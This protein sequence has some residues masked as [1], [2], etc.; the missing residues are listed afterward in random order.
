MEKCFSSTEFITAFKLGRALGVRLAECFGF[1]W[2][3]VDWEKHTIC[4]NKQLLLDDGMWCFENTKTKAAVREID[5]QDEIYTYLKELKQKQEE[6]KKKLMRGIAG[7]L[8]TVQE[9]TC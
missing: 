5:L 7:I 1:L 2:S 6:N 3:D 4:V 9:R 8:R